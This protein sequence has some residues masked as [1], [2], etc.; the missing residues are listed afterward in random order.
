MKKISI[1]VL[2][3]IAGSTVRAS[4]PDSAQHL[5][6]IAAVVSDSIILFSEVEA[7]A[8]LKG[9]QMRIQDPDP[10]QMER[11]RNEALEELI[12]GKVLLV[13]AERDTNITVS[14]SEVQ[15]GVENR[16]EMMLRQNRITQEQLEQVL[17]EQQGIS[18]TKFKSELRTQIRQELMKQKVQQLYASPSTITKKEIRDF[19]NEYKDSLPAAGESIRL[20]KITMRCDPSTQIRQKAY[21]RI[22]AI[23][24]K[25]DN[26]ADFTETAKQ[27]SEGPN[28]ENGGD[29]GFISKGTLG[30]LEFEE[31]VFSMDVGQISEPFETRLGFHVV[32]VEE[33]KNGRSHVRQ[34]L[35]EVSP[36]EACYSKARTSLDSV[37]TSSTSQKEFAQAA[38]SLSDDPVSRR[39]GGKMKWK[40]VATLS[41][42]T[43][44]AVTG[45]EVGDISSIVQEGNALT[46]YRVDDKKESRP[47]TLEEDWNEI[48]QIAQRVLAQQ[49]LRD[50]VKKWRQET[51]IKIN[52]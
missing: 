4:V 24:G 25:L 27:F 51:F 2:L 23:K 11:L 36:D 41:P 49:K 46:I 16:I 8:Y 37:K 22:K 38:R 39:L 44:K 17:R 52:L 34:I 3:L 13:Q 50:L 26:G 14:I 18:L 28:A 31:K 30:L 47:L 15:A 29:L 42:S 7:Y 33:K 1:A 19:Y 35:V 45:L 40:T 5:D 32:T 12:D 10:E 9:Q 20:S 43:A 6:G 21:D 48:A